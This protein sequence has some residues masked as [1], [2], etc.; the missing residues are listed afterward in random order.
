[1]LSIMGLFN[2]FNKKKTAATSPLSK[3]YVSSVLKKYDDMRSQLMAAVINEGNQQ[4]M[5]IVM[6]LHEFACPIFYA[7]EYWGYGHMSD[8]WKEDMCLDIYRRFKS[9][10]VLEEVRK[11]HRSISN[12]FPFRA[13]D[14]DGSLKNATIEVLDRLIQDLEKH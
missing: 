1:M 9:R 6:M 5:Q 14:Q 4:A 13:L 7:W 2:F 11:T 12:L 3:E 10:N 8:F